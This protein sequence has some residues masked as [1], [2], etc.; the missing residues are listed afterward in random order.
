MTKKTNFKKH[1]LA[2]ASVLAIG[3][4]AAGQ[5]NAVAITAGASTANNLTGPTADLTLTGIHTNATDNTAQHVIFDATSDGFTL[6][7]GAFA[8]TSVGGGAAGDWLGTSANTTGN[9]TVTAGGSIS[10]DPNGNASNALDLNHNFGQITNNGTLSAVTTAAGTVIDVAAGITVTGITNSST[11][12]ISAFQTGIGIS[13]AGDSTT[14]TNG[15]LNAGTI[16]ATTTGKAIIVSGTLGGTNATG[17]IYNTGLLTAAGSAGTVNIADVVTNASTG[18]G[19]LN[20][21][22]ISDTNAGVAVLLSGTVGATVVTNSGSITTTGAGVAVSTTAALTG[23]FTN[24]GQITTVTGTGFSA[25]SG[26]DVTAF[27]NSGTIDVTTGGGIGVNIADGRNIATLTNTGII[28][29]TTTGVGVLYAGTHSGS[30]LSNSGTIS[31]T[32]TG[33]AIKVTTSLT[34]ASATGVIYNTKLIQA[35]ASTNGVIDVDGAII[36]STTAG[37]GIVN[38]STGTIQ[39]TGAGSAINIAAAVGV[40]NAG[41]ITSAALVGGTV[42]T[43]N[44]SAANSNATGITNSGTISNTSTG[45]AIAIV[46]GAMT[47]ALTNTG[48]LSSAT[49]SALNV[50]SDL[51]VIAGVING[52]SSVAG[53]MTSGSTTSTLNFA[54]N[55]ATDITNNKGTITNSSTGSA[56]RVVTQLGDDGAAGGTLTNGTSTNTGSL[57]TISAT[58]A[59]T[60]VIADM[61]GAITNYGN[62]TNTSTGAHSAITLAAFTGAS[63]SNVLLTN[64]GT[65]TSA[66]SVNTFALTGES[67]V[68]ASITNSGSISNTGTGGVINLAGETGHTLTITNTGTIAAAASTIAAIVGGSGVDVLNWNNGTITGTI[69]LGGQ[70]ADV[71]NVGDAT[72]DSITTGGAISG[73]SQLEI[74]NGTFNI[75]HGI[76]ITN[77]TE[78]DENFM[79][80][81]STV[82]NV[83]E[84]VTIEAGDVD[85]NGTLQVAAGKTV[86]INAG[87]TTNTTDVGAAG[88]VKVGLS[89]YD[90]TTA[91]I[92]KVVNTANG[93]TFNFA[94]G[95]SMY[96][97]V[98]AS[99][100]VAAGTITDVIT[101]DAITVGG[102]TIDG[103]E[104]SVSC[105]D[106]SYVLSCSVATSTDATGLDI[107]IART[108][109]Y[110][111]SSTIT[112]VK[113]VGTALEAIGQTGDAALDTIAATLDSYTTA[114]EVET[115]L[116]TLDATNSTSG[117]TSQALIAVS[118]AA[119]GT[120]ENRMELARNE[121][122][123]VAT[124]GASASNGVWGDVFGASIDAGEREGVAGYQA[125]V[126]GFA[127]GADTAVNSQTRVGAAFAYGNTDADGTRNET[128]VDSY[129][130]SIYGSYDMGKVYYEGVGSF[131]YNSYDT[132]R[133]LFDGSVANGSFNGQQYSAKGTAGYKVDVQ[134]GLKVT[135]FASAQYTF[136]TQDSY[137][138]TGSNANLH[139]NSD[140]INIF[141][142]G[143]GTKLAYPITEGGV[144]YTPRL[145]AAWYY[146][147]VGDEASTTSNFSS[148]AGTTFASK[149]ADIAQSEFK[150]GAGLDV[151]AQD[152]VTVSLDYS[153][154]TKEDFDAHTGELKA[155]FEF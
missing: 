9:L 44:Q 17:V 129:Q 55:N 78:A 131:A 123:G 95:G 75:G 122:S 12:T 40:N 152:N 59:H 7:T 60:I 155:R 154:N 102:A 43:I 76:T 98:S 37:L 120:V 117:S 142:T 65:I 81:A 97:N 153:W 103:I 114:A 3:A 66:G 148:V 149:G 130:G 150:L 24:S 35:A 25:T 58:G 111:T 127:I 5:A 23:T 1:L 88:I 121:T 151:L 45:H 14:I 36:N 70:T 52:S 112:N 31:A 53:T 101:S 136:L 93:T 141:K 32:T 71:L 48:S 105:A 115:A 33:N 79:V 124:G 2:S 20:A 109:A 118:D 63:A 99:N 19:L 126:G 96:L 144:T 145:S 30:L 61:D 8:H 72:S 116:K 143:L 15:I 6:N 42:A 38:S 106:N 69:N 87:T 138:E 62:I 140:D 80:D 34:G 135:P 46:A 77:A 49:G 22:T 119:T 133:T 108:N 128:T 16:T 54:G 10:N 56:I 137:T 86:T 67:A 90:G 21:G 139:V 27:T 134:G 83:T 94:A 13:V 47:G 89:A 74:K 85:I 125:N 147:F 110:Q 92:G 51:D 26:G 100:F 57:A 107:T 41:L 4:F 11:G 146:D 18:V 39:D 28:D 132:S 73:T 91:T 29:D 84:S 82:A 64:S 68:N 104:S 50:A 113:S